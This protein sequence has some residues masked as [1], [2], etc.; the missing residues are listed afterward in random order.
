MISILIFYIYTRPCL[1][2]RQLQL[3]E[4]LNNKA[5]EIFNI[6]NIVFDRDKH[7]IKNEDHW[8]DASPVSDNDYRSLS[9]HRWLSLYVYNKLSLERTKKLK[10]Q[11]KL[12][13]KN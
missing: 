3:L 8:S 7:E 6:E 11:K 13:D 10:R 1:Y 2:R 5:S 9:I 12:K 4:Y